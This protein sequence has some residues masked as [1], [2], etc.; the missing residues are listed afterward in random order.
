MRRVRRDYNQTSVFVSSTK[1]L[2]EKIHF[3]DSP[4]GV[5]PRCFGRKPGICRYR[6]YCTDSKQQWQ[7]SNHDRHHF[8]DYHKWNCTRLSPRRM[9][10]FGQQLDIFKLLS[11]FANI[12][13]QRRVW[14]LRWSI[15]R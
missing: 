14:S 15:C 1:G 12:R 2:R 10:D 7:L 6:C 13:E 11:R 5:C 3:M 9:G 8:R 4:P